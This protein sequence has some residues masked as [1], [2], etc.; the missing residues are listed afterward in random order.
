MLFNKKAV[1]EK[2]GPGSENRRRPNSIQLPRGCHPHT[3]TYNTNFNYLFDV[4]KSNFTV[5]DEMQ[6]R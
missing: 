2:H 5:G 6:A 3:A 4:F 1:E